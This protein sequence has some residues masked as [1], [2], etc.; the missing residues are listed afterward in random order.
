MA[1]EDKF[2]REIDRIGLI[3]TKLLDLLLG[4]G[5]FSNDEV[6]HFMQQ[7]KTALNL[8]LD[9]FL[10]SDKEVGLDLLIKN[11]KFSNENLHNFGH[12]LYDL[13]HKTEDENQQELLLK[14]AL[15]IYEYLVTD[16]K[17]TL[18]LDVLFRIKELQ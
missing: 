17:G 16:S 18:Y 4:K 3:L 2:K 8:D 9:E 1:Q 11:H 7:C 10:K 15:H 13:A 5:Q 14:K 6:A 12:I